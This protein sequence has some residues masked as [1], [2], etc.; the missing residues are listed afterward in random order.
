[1]LENKTN[2]PKNN[3]KK[4]SP[5]DSGFY[6]FLQILLMGEFFFSWATSLILSD[7][8][9]CRICRLWGFEIEL[10]GC[11]HKNS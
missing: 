4:T 8:D 1:V 7:I 10:F 11:L 6:N 9:V 5:T 3:T 2:K